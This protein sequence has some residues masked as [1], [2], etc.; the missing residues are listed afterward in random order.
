MMKRKLFFAFFCLTA[1][2]QFSNAQVGFQCYLSYT[3]NHDDV[4]VNYSIR[5]DSELPIVV[6]ATEIGTSGIWMYVAKKTSVKMNYVYS[7]Y[8]IIAD[9]KYLTIPPHESRSF[10]IPY[11]IQHD[12]EEWTKFRVRL[13]TTCFW[14]EGTENKNGQLQYEEE[15]FEFNKEDIRHPDVVYPDQTQSDT[16]QMQVLTPEVEL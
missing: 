16:V 7:D 6:P 1:F 2:V 5:N 10:R 14:E 3:D 13:Y 12:M 11:D 4:V 15:I 8:R 9:K